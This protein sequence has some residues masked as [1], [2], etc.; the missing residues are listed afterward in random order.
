MLVLVV[1]ALGAT[2][3]LAIS[4]GQSCT[5]EAVMTNSGQLALNSTCPIIMGGEQQS[6]GDTLVTRSELQEA[7]NALRAELSVSSPTP[8]SPPA[9]PPPAPILTW[10]NVGTGY[11]LD[12]SGNYYEE[13]GIRSRPVT[14]AYCQGY[15]AASAGCMGFVNYNGND[16]GN[17][18][19]NPPY[20]ACAPNCCVLNY[21]SGTRPSSAAGYPSS[22]TWIAGGAASGSGAVSSVDGT[23]MCQCYDRPPPPPPPYLGPLLTG[24]ALQSGWSI[25]SGTAE[26]QVSFSGSGPKGFQW[27]HAAESSGQHYF[28][29]TT[30]SAQG[31]STGGGPTVYSG[32]YSS[33]AAARYGIYSRQSPGDSSDLGLSYSSAGLCEPTWSASPLGMMAAGKTLGYAVDFGAG[34]IAIYSDAAT[35]GT[36]V[37]VGELT[38]LLAAQCSAAP[39]LSPSTGAWYPFVG[40]GASGDNSGSFLLRETALFPVPTGYAWWS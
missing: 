18:Q 30:V 38:T 20:S 4:N 10:S 8:S 22:D 34:T 28:E 26:R 1:A 23:A 40:D 19:I 17:T 21:N 25:V 7:L 3:E 29:I 39:N 12:S 24:V 15:C 11:C 31:S 32:I 6:G 27:W 14:P 16:N 9:A 5:L 13:L 33:T 2:L 36:G 35:T 37:Y